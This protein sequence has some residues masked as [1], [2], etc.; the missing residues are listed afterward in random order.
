MASVRVLVVGEVLW[1]QF[2]NAARLGGAPLNLRTADVVKL[3]AE[4]LQFVHEL[5]GL[6]SEPDEFCRVGCD[7]YHWRAACVS[8]GARGCAMRVDAEYVEAEGCPVDVADTVGAGDAF[9][10]AFLHGLISE[11]PVAKIAE[12]ANR[13]GAF[14]AGSHGAIPDQTPDAILDIVRGR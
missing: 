14:V 1:D 6:P 7:Q 2:P 3:N 9:A 10:A 13:I 12:F 4:E 5:V 11:W 8:L